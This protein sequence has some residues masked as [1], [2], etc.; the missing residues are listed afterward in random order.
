MRP[1]DLAFTLVICTLNR[2][3]LLARALEAIARQM[4]DFRNGRLIVVD[5]GSTDGT[6]DYLKALSLE[7]R[8]LTIMNHA[9]RGLYYARCAALREASGE[10]VLFLDD[11]TVPGE[12]WIEG[13]LAEFAADSTVGCVGSAVKPI[14]SQAPPD[15]LNERLLRVIPIMQIEGGRQEAAFPC[16][17]PGLSLAIRRAPCL[18]VYFDDARREMPLG[19]SGTDAARKTGRIGGEDN[20][21][22]EIYA[23]NGYRVISVDHICV[24]HEVP[25]DRLDAVWFRRSFRAAG[26]LRVRLARITGRGIFNRSVLRMLMALPFTIAAQALR[27]ALSRGNE[28]LVQCYLQKCLGAWSELISGPRMVWPYTMSEA[29]SAKSARETLS[30]KGAA[31]APSAD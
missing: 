25:V 22:C 9:E 2:R 13:T 17:P 15:W 10:F 23:R 18:E 6:G 28:L 30:R 11:D 27:P 5:N 14:F 8:Q 12:G 26:H 3:A 31:A 21:L 29:L 20:D 4:A 19:I 7:L 1:A 16:Y 24:Y